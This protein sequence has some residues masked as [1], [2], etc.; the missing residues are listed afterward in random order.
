MSNIEFAQPCLG[1]QRTEVS[2][3]FVCLT[4]D[5]LLSEPRTPGQ[6]SQ[7]AGQI[8]IIQN[9]EFLF[10]PERMGKLIRHSQGLDPF[11]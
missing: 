8:A 10:T 9:N 2:Q 6:R 5:I 4:P 3:D 11:I 1:L 7:G